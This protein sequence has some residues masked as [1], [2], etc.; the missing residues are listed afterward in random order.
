MHEVSDSESNEAYAEAVAFGDY[1][2]A[3]QAQCEGRPE[4]AAVVEP[5]QSTC[6]CTYFVWSGKHS[7]VCNAFAPAV[8][9]NNA[10]AC[11][12]H[13]DP[14]DNERADECCG[15][16][17]PAVKP[18]Q[19]THD[20]SNRTAGETS[21]EPKKCKHGR[22]VRHYCEMCNATIRQGE[23]T[24]AAALRDTT[25]DDAGGKR[26][27]GLADGAAME[28]ARIER[29]MDHVYETWLGRH[30][31]D[32]KVQWHVQNYMSDLRHVIDG[33]VQ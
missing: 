16:C 28:R 30:P 21:V 7:P 25:T 17:A 2:A 4:C 8:K 12:C 10:C 3:L 20:T 14:G 19:P 13:T 31:C 26:R 29:I 22:P 1:G 24:R 6:N 32:E 9:P 15:A 11:P 5:E 23:A 33:G 27:R 18:E